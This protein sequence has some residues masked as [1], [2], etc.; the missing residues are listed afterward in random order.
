MTT[1]RTIGRVEPGAEPLAHISQTTYIV[2]DSGVGKTSLLFSYKEKKY[3]EQIP[4]VGSDLHKCEV[5]VD[6]L[7]VNLYVYDTSG[8]KYFQE[9]VFQLMRKSHFLIFVFDLSDFET[10]KNIQN[11]WIP[12]AKSKFEE[13][14]LVL[15]PFILVGNKVDLPRSP[16]LS[17]EMIQNVVDEFKCQYI[18][19]S[20]RTGENVQQV[21]DSIVMEVKKRVDEGILQAEKPTKRFRLSVEKTKSRGCC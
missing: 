20:A 7:Q 2:G 13:S 15:P 14:N 18:E 5:T 10:W 17:S 9:T 12:K 6:T 11:D 4:T 16:L 8:Q 21:F 3:N 1:R 19:S